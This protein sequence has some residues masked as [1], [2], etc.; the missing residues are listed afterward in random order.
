M[1][2]IVV[3]FEVPSFILPDVKNASLQVNEVGDTVLYTIRV[4]T[5]LKQTLCELIVKQSDAQMNIDKN[6]VGPQPTT[7]P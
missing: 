3:I 5:D 7:Q 4:D 6:I 2:K 1:T